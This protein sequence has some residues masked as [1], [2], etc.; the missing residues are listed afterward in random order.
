M[1]TRRRFIT[2]ATGAGAL[3]L[4]TNVS[5]PLA[6]ATAARG[7]PD[8]WEWK[9]DVSA[10]GWPVDGEISVHAVDGSLAAAALRDGAAATVLLHVLRRWHYE[11]GPVDTEE[12]GGLTAHTTD[13][14][15]AADFESNQ[16]SG[17]AVAVYPT[18]YPLKGTEGL[19]PYQEVI[20][21]D[22]LLDCAGTVRWGGD[23]TPVKISHFHIDVPP[24]SKK[25]AQVAE[26]LHT[27]WHTAVP[28]LAGAAADPAT[29]ERR[30]R[31]RRLERQQAD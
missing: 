13:R 27:G 6:A 24:G 30:A 1:I 26:R 8:R 20:V 19:R 28:P 10:N 12:G 22:I 29:P 21:R 14:T 25:L 9:G 18:A 17:T 23:L 7:D 4:A 31:A 2:A 5:P 15:V 3:M 11:I 16:L